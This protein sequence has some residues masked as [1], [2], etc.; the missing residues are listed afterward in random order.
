MHAE[1]KEFLLFLKDENDLDYGDFKRVVDLR[2]NR[3]IQELRPL[4]REQRF[5]LSK[6]REELL[7]MYNDDVDEMKAHLAEEIARLDP[8]G[9]SRASDAPF[10]L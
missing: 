7:W 5:R 8:N 10:Q 4:N 9:D 3:L 6:L 1:I 2:L